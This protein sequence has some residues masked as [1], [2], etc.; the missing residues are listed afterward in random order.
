MFPFPSALA[1]VPIEGWG[2][3][4]N[5]AVHPLVSPAQLLVIAGLA[6][7][8][9][10]QV[11]LK[12][13]TPMLFFASAAAASLALTVTGL[14]PEIPPPVIAAIALCL[15]ALVA[16]ARPP[17][18]HAIHAFCAVSGI[19]LGLDSGVESGGA[20]AVAQTLAGT[21]LSLILLT[22]YITLASSNAAGKPIPANA[23]RVLG[24]WIVAISLLMLA[25]G[26]RGSG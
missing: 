13:R 19:I 22:G 6:L 3:F 14:F 11:P 16:V 17:H 20:F 21:W 26:M 12:V 9:G 23:I 24:S 18:P 4:A 1:H 25:F 10:Q 15:G 2:D 5:G 8:L 7:L